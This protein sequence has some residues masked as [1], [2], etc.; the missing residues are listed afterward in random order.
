MP[1]TWP[2][3]SARLLCLYAFYGDPTECKRA[4]LSGT[5]AYSHFANNASPFVF[6]ALSGKVPGHKRNEILAHFVEYVSATQC[7]YFSQLRR[8][9]FVSERVFPFAE[10]PNEDID[11]HFRNAHHYLCRVDGTQPGD[12]E[13]ELRMRAGANFLADGDQDI[14]NRLKGALLEAN[15]AWGDLRMFSELCEGSRVRLLQNPNQ[16]ITEVMQY[17]TH[18]T[19]AL[20]HSVKNDRK[21]SFD[22]VKAGQRHLVRATL[23][24]RK[25]II[26][27][28]LGHD[29][30][31]LSRAALSQALASRVEE[32]REVVD[33]P[34]KLTMY[35]DA[36]K[37]IIQTFRPPKA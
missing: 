14:L 6:N 18:L 27:T 34:V 28:A 31:I 37:S 26:A 16:A 30:E 9:G 19:R 24:M 7:A 8:L 20:E 15:D 1:G 17:L 2:E 32:C 3:T 23:D 12:G 21:K 10:L 5:R 13:F 33:A 22:E 35:K 36:A 29:R 25:S 11:A 4:L